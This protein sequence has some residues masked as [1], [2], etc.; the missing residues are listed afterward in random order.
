[1]DADGTIT[2]TKPNSSNFQLAIAASQKTSE[3]LSPLVELYGGHI[4]IDKGGQ[5]SF[6]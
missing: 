1:V 4:Y 3:I 6:K 5:G 2:I